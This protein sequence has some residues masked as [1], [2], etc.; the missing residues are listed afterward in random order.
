M[1]LNIYTYIYLITSVLGTYT[2]YKFMMVFFESPEGRNRLEFISYLMY[3]AVM[4]IIYLTVNI[5]IVTL[6][7]NILLYFILSLNYES[8]FKNRVIS[9]IMI[10]VVL[11]SIESIIALISGY[12]YISILNKNPSYTS[13]IGMIAIGIVSYM[14][15]LLLG[16]YKNIKKGI[17]IPNIYWL[18]IFLIPLGSLYII[19]SILQHINRNTFSISISITILFLINI[20]IFYLYDKLTKAFEENLEKT[21]LKE[22]N[23]YYRGQLEIINNSHNSFKSLSHDMKNHMTVLKWY[24]TKGDKQKALS[25]ISEIDDISYGNKEYSSTGNIDIDSILNFKFQEAESKDISVSLESTVPSNFNI[26]ASDIVIILGNLLDNAIEA[27]LKVLE[28]KKIDF[29]IKYKNNILF[30]SI[31]NIFDGNIIYEKSKIKTTK[32]DKE[33]HGIGLNNIRSILKK[34]NGTMEIHHTEDRFSVDILMYVD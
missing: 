9:I 3:F 14:A 4:N 33:N 7:C 20:I 11:I 15:A 25:Y 30:I 24:I 8:S 5:P 28:D 6:M 1:G 12:I 18:S 10:Y 27:S 34:Y 22:Q 32:E 26:P 17:T 31:T 19:L 2:T 16:N 23:K 13:T 29:R 21:I